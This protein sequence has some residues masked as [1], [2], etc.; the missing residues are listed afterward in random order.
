[1]LL[2]PMSAAASFVLMTISLATPAAAGR[3]GHNLRMDDLPTSWVKLSRHH[4][5]H[6]ARL[7]G[8]G[9][10][11]A[12]SS[13]PNGAGFGMGPTGQPSGVK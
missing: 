9:A 4:K 7:P 2:K 11:T 10:G 5:A 12:S 8:R 1:M 13:A 3:T 6:R